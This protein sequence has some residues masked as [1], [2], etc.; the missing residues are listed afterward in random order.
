MGMAVDELPADPV[1]HAVQVEAPLLLLHTGVEDD[2]EQ[3]V[4]QLF[5]QMLGAALI[6][7]LHRLIGFLQKIAAD[8]LVGLLRIPGASPGRPENAH[9]LF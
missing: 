3:N 9:D 7:G 4:P 8:R 6:D 2:L 5:P 1:C